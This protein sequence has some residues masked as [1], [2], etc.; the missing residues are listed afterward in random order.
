[1]KKLKPAIAVL[2]IA[3]TAF[4]SCATVFGGHV[5]E[6]QRTKPVAGQPTRQVRV[7]ALIADILLFTPGI[8]ID[9]AT[10]AIYKPHPSNDQAQPAAPAA[11]STSSI[12][13]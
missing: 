11:S 5:N 6:Y 7:G 1:M 8:I 9:F 13:Q 10:C 3:C 12:S 4:S 2:F